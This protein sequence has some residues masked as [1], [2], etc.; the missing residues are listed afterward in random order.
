M[1]NLIAILLAGAVAGC[2]SG[3]APTPGSSPAPSPSG[4][5]SVTPAATPTQTPTPSPTATPS[6]TG[7]A[8]GWLTFTS[9]VFGYSIQYPPEWTV[10]GATEGSMDNFFSDSLYPSFGVSRAAK[11][12][13]MTEVIAS[14]TE[15]YTSNYS[16]T[17]VSDEPVELADGY[18]GRILVLQGVQNKININI[19]VVFAAKDDVGYLIEWFGWGSDLE[20]DKV[21]FEEMYAT[22]RPG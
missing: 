19:Q 10:Q 14:G 13:S 3:A 4:A 1:S 6:T 17:L 8:T 16:A 11:T 5:S 9:D 21:L 15:Y 2:G 7:T 20:V 18:A 12:V 22:W